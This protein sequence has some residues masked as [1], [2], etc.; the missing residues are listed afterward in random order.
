MLNPDKEITPV[1]W[2]H[3]IFPLVVTSLVIPDF[4]LPNSQKIALLDTYY[5][6]NNILILSPTG[7]IPPGIVPPMLISFGLVYGFYVAWL[8]QKAK[9]IN[10]SAFNKINR[11]TLVWLNLLTISV[12]LFFTFQLLQFFSLA[13]NHTYDP[14]SQVCK[15]LI[16]ITLCTYLIFVPN[17][18]EIMDGCIIQPIKIKGNL[19]DIEDIIPKLLENFNKNSLALKIDEISKIEKYYLD[20]SFDLISMSNVLEISP[21]KLSGYIRLF[22]GMSFVEFINRLRIHYFLSSFNHFD[23]FTLE[24]YIYN[25]GFSSRSTFYT[26]FKKHVGI[27]PKA[28][29]K[30]ISN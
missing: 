18:H 5:K 10:G 8:I 13:F 20:K 1:Q 19:P 3:F 16:V 15:C 7:L 22:Y 6:Q 9:I 4:F 29:L 25:S 11:E 23:T 26:S 14:I 28:Y 12:I 24:T 21:I 2:L 27:N 17:V 30:A